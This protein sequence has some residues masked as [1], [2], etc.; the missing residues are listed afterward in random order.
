MEV[1]D[2]AKAVAAER[3]RAAK[4]E[5]AKLE[6]ELTVRQGWLGTLREQVGL[7]LYCSSDL[8]TSECPAFIC[9]T[10]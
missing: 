4:S 7:P 10:P 9:G 2:S 5:G 6:H 3:L 1:W 8:L